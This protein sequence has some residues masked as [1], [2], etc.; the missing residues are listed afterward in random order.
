MSIIYKERRLRSGKT[1]LRTF[2][3][4]L[5]LTEMH[6]YELLD[7]GIEIRFEAGVKVAETYFAKRQPVVRPIYE[8]ARS[9]YADMPAA[10][11]SLKD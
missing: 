9:K 8:K 11:R 5:L 4:G 3:E 6:L 2:S 1:T 10:D 7:I